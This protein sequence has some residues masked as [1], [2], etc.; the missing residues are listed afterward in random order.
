MVLIVKNIDELEVM[1]TE[2]ITE[3]RKAGLN[4]NFQKTKILG[5]GEKKNIRVGEETIDEVDE[6]VYLGPLLS[7]QKRNKGKN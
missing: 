1:L 7:F 6:I 4:I 3:G 2:L 5:K